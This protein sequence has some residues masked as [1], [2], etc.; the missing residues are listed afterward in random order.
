MEE[1]VE[2]AKTFRY[3]LHTIIVENRHGSTNEHGVPDVTVNGMRDRFE[4][5]L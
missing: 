4:I 3:R 5:K 2:L 1:Y